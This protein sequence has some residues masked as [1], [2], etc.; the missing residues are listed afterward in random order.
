MAKPKTEKQKLYASLMNSKK[1]LKLAKNAKKNGEKRF[2]G[3]STQSAI[4]ELEYKIDT[5]NKQRAA[6]KA[7]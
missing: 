6:L 1:Q 4:D 5:I 7:K 3:T 2:N